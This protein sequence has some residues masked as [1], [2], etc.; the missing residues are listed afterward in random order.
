L[1][2][3]ARVHPSMRAPD[4]SISPSPRRVRG[5]GGC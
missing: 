1:H 2:A 4:L 3:G 5:R